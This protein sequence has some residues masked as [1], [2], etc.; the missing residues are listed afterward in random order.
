MTVEDSYAIQLAQIAD[1][2]AAGRWVIGHKV[3]LTSAAMQRQLGV[4][5][6]TT[7]TSPTT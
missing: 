5:Q 3:G 1:R 4:N 7:V 2:L 6:P